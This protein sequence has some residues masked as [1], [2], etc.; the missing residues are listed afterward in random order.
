MGFEKPA[1]ICKTCHEKMQNYPEQFEWVEQNSSII[2]NILKFFAAFLLEN[3]VNFIYLVLFYSTNTKSV[4]LDSF[5]G[6]QRAAP[7]GGGN[8]FAGGRRASRSPGDCRLRS[9]YHAVGCEK[10]T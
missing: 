7:G 5:G 8:G 10:S 3:L 9:H 2:L 4:Q 1:R 6:D